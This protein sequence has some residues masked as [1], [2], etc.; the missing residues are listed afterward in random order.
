MAAINRQGLEIPV[1]ISGTLLV[2]SHAQLTDA[3][4]IADQ[5][6]KMDMAVCM[7][8]YHSEKTDAQYAEYAVNA[9]LERVV[10]LMDKGPIQVLSARTGEKQAISLSDLLGGKHA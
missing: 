2:Y 8:A 10:F 4:E 5:L 1:D 7:I 6:R 3:I 9:Q